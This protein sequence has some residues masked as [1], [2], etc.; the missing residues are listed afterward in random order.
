VE[1]TPL[2]NATGLI[3]L[4]LGIFL[5]FRCWKF[6][7]FVVCVC[8]VIVGAWLG[9]GRRPV[10]ISAPIPAAIGV[11]LVTGIAY[12]TYRWWL[13]RRIG[14]GAFRSRVIF[15]SAG[16]SAALSSH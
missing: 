13:A 6:E 1:N 5:A 11:V 10:N 9:L 16:R 3:A 7:R 2:V 15:S 8:G 14:L 12:R 4:L